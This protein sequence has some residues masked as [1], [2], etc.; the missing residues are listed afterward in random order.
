MTVPSY[1]YYLI[2]NANEGLTSNQ[3]STVFTNI[4]GGFGL[5]SS[6][7]VRQIKLGDVYEFAEQDD[8]ELSEATRDSLANIAGLNFID[9]RPCVD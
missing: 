6:R 4:D 8:F 3:A 7:Q 2:N 9:S 1:N 5:F